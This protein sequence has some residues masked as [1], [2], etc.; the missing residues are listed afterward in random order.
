MFT[1]QHHYMQIFCKL[2]Y[3]KLPIKRQCLADFHETHAWSITL[4]NNCHTEILE[5]P[6]EGSATDMRSRTDD[7]IG[8][9]KKHSFIS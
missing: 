1:F 4:V 6:T 7:V 3:L 5:N 9:N 8:H 2:L